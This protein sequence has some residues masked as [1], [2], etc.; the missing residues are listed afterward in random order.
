MSNSLRPHGLQRTRLP[1]PSQSPGASSNSCSLSWWCHPSILSSVIP[2]SS[3]PQSFPASESFPMSHFFTTGG[4]S[5]GASVSA[6][7][8]LMNIHDWFLLEL[9]DLI[10]LQSKG[11][12]SIFSNT[13]VQKHQFFS[14]QPP[15]G[16]TLTFIHDY[17]KNHS[18]D[19]TF[20][21]KVMS[22]LLNM[23]SRLVI[24][25]LPRSKHLLISWLQSPFAVIF[26]AHENKVHHC[27]HCLPI[28]LP[29]S[30]GTRCHDLHFLN[31]DF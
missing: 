16:P 26:G 31:V 20:V 18:F 29:W 12:S 3:C 22:L 6:S 30:D 7:V 8:L 23:L 28:Y 19:Q 15:F 21:G 13:I 5:I 1:C 27:F 17:W 2:F 14:T 9:T 24:A 4:Q 11:L 25:F 10:S